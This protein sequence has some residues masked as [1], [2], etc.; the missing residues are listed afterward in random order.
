MWADQIARLPLRPL[1]TLDEIR[2]SS[3]REK[4]NNRLAALREAKARESAR[5]IA[6]TEQRAMKLVRDQP[7]ITIQDL[8]DQMRITVAH[9][10]VVTKRLE[11]D[12]RMFHKVGALNKKLWFVK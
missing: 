5:K 7:G 1:P 4:N 12:G 9:T 3:H 8:A 10:R 2:A 11:E 6:G